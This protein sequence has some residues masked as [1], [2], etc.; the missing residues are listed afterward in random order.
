[1]LIGNLGSPIMGAVS[2]PWYDINRLVYVIS[3]EEFNN[4]L[5]QSTIAHIVT[6]LLIIENYLLSTSLLKI[7]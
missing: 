4:F 2:Y 6:K 3:I 7:T 5:K 1:M